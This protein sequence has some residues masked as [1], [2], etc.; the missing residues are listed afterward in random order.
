M[1]LITADYFAHILFVFKTIYCLL[2]LENIMTPTIRQLP[3]RFGQ[4]VYACLSILKE[5]T[6]PLSMDL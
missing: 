4:S 1:S 5:H 2:D 6:H 3:A